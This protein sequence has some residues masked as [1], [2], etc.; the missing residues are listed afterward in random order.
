MERRVSAAM[1]LPAMLPE[2]AEQP[3]DD[4]RYVF[5]PKIDGQRMI[6]SME[7]GKVRLYTKKQADVT[8]QYPELHRVPVQDG[9]DLV[10]DGEAACIHPETGT[11][12][13]GA[14]QERAMLR[15]PMSIMEGAVRRP[16]TFFAFDVLRYKGEDLRDLPLMQRKALLDEILEENERFSRVF[17]VEE[18]GS[19]LFELIR[20]KQLDGMV[21][22]KKDS[23]YKGGRSSDWL[24]MISY[25]Y[26][27]VQIAGY[28]KRQFGWLLQ[29]E[30]QQVGILELPVPAAYQKA[31]NAVA[32][33]IMTGEDDHFVYV[34]P[35]ITVK[36]RYR[37]RMND[38]K[39]RLPEFVDFVV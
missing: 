2:V 32:K 27:C 13:F 14:I 24:K 11:A 8:H 23:R 18:S 4:G 12:D 22:K 38:G 15:K 20:K 16:V 26:A 35:R 9:S 19:S 17:Y 30:G 7:N 6:L 31:F 1:F 39:I 34:E 25:S 29:D 3:F 28:R 36:I 37:T 21:A 33:C 5:E 10:L